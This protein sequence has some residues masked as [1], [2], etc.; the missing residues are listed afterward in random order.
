[1]T[2]HWPAPAAVTAAA[3]VAAA[4]AVTVAVAIARGKFLPG[5]EPVFVADVVGG[6]FCSRRVLAQVLF[7][8]DAVRC[9]VN[10]VQ[11]STQKLL[12]AAGN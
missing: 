5:L 8:G 1:M 11:V 12:S 10:T 6:T 9:G 2:G 4:V 7:W 3:A